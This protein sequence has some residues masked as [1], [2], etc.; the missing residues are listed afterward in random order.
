MRKQLFFDDSMWP[1]TMEQVT[2][3]FKEKGV[4]VREAEHFFQ[5]YQLK[6]WRSKKGQ[7]IRLWKNAANSWIFLATRGQA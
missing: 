7:M 4:S 5:L 6:Q 1:P 3:Y 2:C